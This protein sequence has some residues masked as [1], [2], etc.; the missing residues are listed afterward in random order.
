MYNYKKISIDG[1][2]FYLRPRTLQ[3]VN[4]AARA[5]TAYFELI[6]ADYYGVMPAPEYNRLWQTLEINVLQARRCGAEDMLHK[7]ISDYLS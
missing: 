3:G 4:A 7:G 1:V 5:N 2:D 6:D